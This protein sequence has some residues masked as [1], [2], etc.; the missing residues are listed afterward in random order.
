MCM[1]ASTLLPQTKSP[2][3]YRGLIADIAVLAVDSGM[4]SAWWWSYC[5]VR[6]Y[7]FV[8]VGTQVAMIIPVCILC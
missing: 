7:K 2:Y 6:R 3:L 8:S 1:H 5:M 4:D